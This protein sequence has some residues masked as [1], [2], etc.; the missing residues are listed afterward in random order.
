MPQQGGGEATMLALSL[1][2]SL[3]AGFQKVVLSSPIH[4]KERKS[5]SSEIYLSGRIHRGGQTPR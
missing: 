1:P 3:L 2:W 4:K 5:N